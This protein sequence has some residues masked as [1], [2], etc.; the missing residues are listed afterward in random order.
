LAAEV[1]LASELLVRIPAHPVWFWLLLGAPF[2][3]L[4]VL[5]P[6][7]RSGKVF[8]KPLKPWLLAGSFLFGPT[9]FFLDVASGHRVLR[10]ASGAVFWTCWLTLI[11]ID[12]WYRFETLRAPGSKWYIPW[13]AAKFSIPR[14]MR[15]LVRDVSAVSPWYI[16]KLGLRKLAEKPGLSPASQLTNSSMVETQLYLAPAGIS[17]P[18]RLQ[19]CSPKESTESK[20]Y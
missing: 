12:Y 11:L 2:L 3:I 7:A 4:L 18:K 10:L 6:I 8:L 9:Y 19:Y 20:M 14:S 17:K 5:W 1:C 15:I 13:N 16:E